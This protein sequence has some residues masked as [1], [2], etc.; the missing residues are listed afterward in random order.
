MAWRDPRL[1][2]SVVTNSGT[3]AGEQRDALIEDIRALKASLPV[4]VF[5]SIRKKYDPSVNRLAM[6]NLRELQA[7]LQAAKKG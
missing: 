4:D 2:L 5:T 3:L 6:Q 7:E 1:N